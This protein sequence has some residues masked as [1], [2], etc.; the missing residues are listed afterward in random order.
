MKPLYLMLFWASLTSLAPAAPAQQNNL[1]S[2]RAAFVCNAESDFT[3]LRSAPT[4]RGSSILG[5]VPNGVPVQV[6]GVR[7]NEAGYKYYRV[8]LKDNP[9][10]KKRSGFIYED[11]VTEKCTLP[12]VVSAE[13]RDLAIRLAAANAGISPHHITDVNADY[14]GTQLYL[15]NMPDLVDLAALADETELT[16]LDLSRSGVSD[17]TPLSNL[18]SLQVLEPRIE[19]L[20][21]EDSHTL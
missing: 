6:K 21:R 9:T 10:G 16:F 14:D 20:N 3:N 19:I 4:A 12:Q 8:E 2:N 17:L 11:A 7:T 13:V 5:Q 15:I 1:Q 18:T